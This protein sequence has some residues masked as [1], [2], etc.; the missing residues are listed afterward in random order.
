MVK[1]RVHKTATAFI[2]GG[3]FILLGS[4]F[5]IFGAI[6]WGLVDVSRLGFTTFYQNDENTPKLVKVL[7]VSSTII[8]TILL[9]LGLSLCT[10]T[11]F[12]LHRVGKR[13]KSIS[14]FAVG[15]QAMSRMDNKKTFSIDIKL[16]P[17]QPYPT[18]SE[19]SRN[20]STIASGNRVNIMVFDG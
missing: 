7:G 6:A 9:I 1:K 18:S 2:V 4:T 19:C 14:H 12:L 8:G 13:L 11:P 3:I 16:G 20:Q 10:L 17:D 15:L 5:L